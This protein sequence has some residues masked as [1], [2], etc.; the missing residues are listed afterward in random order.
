M[1][2]I[3]ILTGGTSSEREVSLQSGEN[4]AA[5]LS[6]TGKY[7][8]VKVVLDEDNLNALPQGISKAYI[9]MHGGWGENGG[10]QKELDKLKIP[11][12][13]PGS[14][15]SEI[16]MD[17]IKTKEVVASAGI[18]TAA[19]K[20]ISDI[21]E[22]APF[23]YPFV[24]KV[25]RDGS[26]FGVYLVKTEN[27]Y[28]NALKECLKADGKCAM[29][30]EFIAGRE[31]TVGIIGDNVLTPIEIVTA[32]GWYGFQEKYVSEETRYPFISEEPLASELKEIAL[33]A[34]KAVG[35]RSI[36]RIDFRIDGD[37]VPYFLEINT[38]P[39]FTSHSLVPKAGMNTGRSFAEVCEMVL[40][41]A[42]HD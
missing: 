34:Y 21:S 22:P 18:K 20:V 39:G 10:L 24:V 23:K 27:E 33:K 25:P 7:D 32:S 3:V 26:S 16:A 42:T 4:I 14:A 19:W 5:A 29:A 2:K 9:A 40:E 13:G 12:T 6:S 37:G 8:V 15:A 28:K 1:E 41:T 38:S 35:C 17:K 36:S 11:Y 31:A 30:E